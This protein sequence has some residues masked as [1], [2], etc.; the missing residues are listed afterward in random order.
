MT[1]HSLAVLI[2]ND[3]QTVFEGPHVQSIQQLKQSSK[4]DFQPGQLLLKQAIDY[5]LRVD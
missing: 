1:A 4:A 5:V 2:E 3:E